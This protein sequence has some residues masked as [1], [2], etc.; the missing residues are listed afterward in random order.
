M[1]TIYKSYQ[2]L[3]QAYGAD[4]AREMLL[5]CHNQA[6]NN[7]SETARRM[8][9]NR[10]TVMLSLSKQ[11]QGNMAD[12]SHRPHAQPNQTSSAVEAMVLKWREKTKRGKRRL[13]R[14]L[15]DEE[16]IVVPIS[17]VG[18][19]LKRN[20]VKI[21]DR[22]RKHR[23]KNPPAYDFS[24][25]LPFEKFQYDTK[26]YLDKQALKQEL[27]DHVLKHRLPQYQWTIIDVKS[28]MRFLSWSYSLTRSCGMAFEL[29]VKAWLSAHG[30]AQGEIEVQSDGGMEVGAIR[31]KSFER[32][33]ALWWNPLGMNRKV[34]RKGRPEDDSFV[35]RSHL[36]DDEDFYIPFLSK[37]TTEQEL[38]SRGLW[39]QDYY[40]RIRPH[41]S[42]NDLS[43][44]QYLKSKGYTLPESFCRF[45]SIILDTICVEPE[46]IEWQKVVHDQFDYY[47]TEFRSE[48]NT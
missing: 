16:R 33:Q 34:I 21:R 14:I 46:V 7:I 15:L 42:L 22:K 48:C 23:S 20:K 28:R 24:S 40:N 30:L 19:I 39:W 17:T 35:E 43:P 38:L 27:Y 36:T 10:R 29:L 37:I 11:E 44:Y 9:C 4:V 3:K 47:Q 12:T 2:Q 8:K 31:K 41:S 13:H 25:L 45:P 26:N 18:K 6:S 1:V 32:N 5:E